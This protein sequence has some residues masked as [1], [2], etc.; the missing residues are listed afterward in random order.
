MNSFGELI[1]KVRYEYWRWFISRCIW[2]QYFRFDGWI[3][4]LSCYLI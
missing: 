4:T 3:R 1:S 2:P